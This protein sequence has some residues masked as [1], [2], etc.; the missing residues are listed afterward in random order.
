MWACKLLQRGRFMKI[1][2]RDSTR[3]CCK[4]HRFD[5]FSFR[6]EINYWPEQLGCYYF[7]FGNRGLRIFMVWMQDAWFSRDSGSI[8]ICKIIEN[9][10]CSYY[11]LNLFV[12][13]L[14]IN[15]RYCC[16]LISNNVHVCPWKDNAVQSN[17]TFKLEFIV[18]RKRKLSIY[19]ITLLF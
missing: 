9:I 4:I 10:A 5:I 12:L 1:T 3:T 18:V 8:G 6:T 7:I 19:Y 2:P 14:I 15:L 11:V 13:L 16:F 17:L